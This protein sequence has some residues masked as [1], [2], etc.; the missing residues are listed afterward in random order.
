MKLIVATNN[1]H[2]V[3]EFRRILEP[4]GFDVISQKEAGI[5][6]DVEETGTT[7]EE[8]AMLKA[9]GVYEL[10][11]CPTV[12][13]DSG[14]EVDYLDKAPGIY[15]ARYGG[16][17]KTEREKCELLLKELDGV[18]DAQRTARFVSAIAVIFS[19]SDRR[20]FLGRCEGKIG[21]AI[22][23]ENGFGYDPIFMVSESDSFATL[24][25]QEKDRISHRGN[26]LR[27]MEQSIKETMPVMGKESG[28]VNK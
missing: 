9:Q 8:N 19:D 25:E 22:K 7:F 11:G 24:S 13:D 15:S 5:T 14:V 21:T 2:K 17:G 10:S 1:A 26:A 28:Y 23:G 18:P 27:K 20:T 16:P 4:L 3:V 6:I 12:A